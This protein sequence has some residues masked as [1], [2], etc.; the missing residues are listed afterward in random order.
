MKRNRQLTEQEELDEQ[1]NRRAAE[2]VPGAGVYFQGEL[3][4]SAEPAVPSNQPRMMT[5]SQAKEQM[6]IQEEETEALNRQIRRRRYE[7]RIRDYWRQSRNKPEPW[8]IMAIHM[9]SMDFFNHYTNP[10]WTPGDDR[11][12]YTNP[13]WAPM[14]H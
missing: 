13:K 2:Q 5:V 7:R 11:T 8:S 3:G 6:R 9:R 12:L 10:K 14:D 4:L 1:A